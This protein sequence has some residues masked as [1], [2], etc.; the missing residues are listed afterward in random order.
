MK[1][2]YQ[3]FPAS[4]VCLFFIISAVIICSRRIDIIVNPQLWAEDGAIWLSTIYNQGFWTGILSPQNGYYQSISRCSYGLGL[5][6]G[7][8]YAPLVANVIAIAIRCSLA[9]FWVSKRFDFIDMKYRVLL[10]FY[11]LLMPNLAEGYV[12]ITN[13]H[14]YLS[15]Y[16]LSVLLANPASSFG[17]KFHDMLVLLLSALSGPFVIFITPCLAIKRYY[18]RG[19]ILA[20]LKKVNLFD[21]VMVLCFCVQFIAILTTSAGTRSPA[22]LGASIFGLFEILQN[23]VFL[24]SF[25]D[26]SLILSWKPGHVAIIIFVLS[27]LAAILYFAFVGN[28]RV[29]ISILFPVLMLSFALAKPMISDTQ[30]Q[31]PPMINTAGGERYFYL[32]NIFY[33]S[34]LL[35]IV[36][37]L[38]NFKKTENFIF[39]SVA[40]IFLYICPKYFFIYPHANL[41]YKEQIIR[42]EQLPSGEKMDIAITPPGWYMRLNKK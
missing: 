27:N 33:F 18:E 41:H 15:L 8:Q 30:P 26:L 21:I 39:L 38:R 23:R 19:G 17:G 40:V 34:F 16:L 10:T 28:W 25:F 20:G 31:W 42:F 4:F 13:A 29:K 7:L 5:L 2:T 1:K 6:F 22:P 37:H 32:P 9:A 14:W 24:A 12:N 36:S 3:D 11:F 35:L